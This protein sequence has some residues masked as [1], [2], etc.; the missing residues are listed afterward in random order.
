[1]DEKEFD[2]VGD[3]PRIY[4]VGF[5]ILSTIAEDALGAEV[6]AVRDV[7]EAA[8]GK[9]IADEYPRHIDLAYP[10]L[11]VAANKRAY[12]H[13]AYFGW[14]KFEADSAAIKKINTA[15]KG[16]DNILRFI[17]VKTVRENTFAPKKLL[18]E[19]RMHDD[20]A[21]EEKDDK[22]RSADAPKM[23][24]EELDKTIEEL[25]IS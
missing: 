11:H 9:L 6:T 13:T 22:T 20:R 21:D 23:T 10:M 3:D 16:N 8:G 15:L 18:R 14:M 2:H 4:E 1:M 5:H 19:R 25:V 12:H 7:I 17:V 24:E